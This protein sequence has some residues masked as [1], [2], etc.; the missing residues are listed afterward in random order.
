MSNNNFSAMVDY[1]NEYRT[2]PVKVKSTQYEEWKKQW[3]F[4]A[5]AGMRYGESFCKYFGVTNGSP[6]YF[7]KDN[8][9]SEHW[10]KD[11]YIEK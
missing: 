8:K 11:N 7:F 4:D 2:V 3:I 9:V 5:L 10:I 6:L 1:L